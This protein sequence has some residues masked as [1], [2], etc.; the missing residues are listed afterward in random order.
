VQGAAGVTSGSSVAGVTV[1]LAP[2]G[3][4]RSLR[5]SFEF[6]AEVHNPDPLTALAPGSANLAPPGHYM[7]FIV[8]ANGVPAVAKILHLG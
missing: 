6:E 5:E 1:A 8:N 2:R 3:P 7:L 4:P